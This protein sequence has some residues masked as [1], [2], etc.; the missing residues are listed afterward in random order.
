MGNCSG[1]L[2]FRPPKDSLAGFYGVSIGFCRV[3]ADM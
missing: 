2:D 3:V 1:A